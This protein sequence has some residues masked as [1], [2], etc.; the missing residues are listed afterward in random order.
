M[1]ANVQRQL[2]QWELRPDGAPIGGTGSTIVPVR[3]SDGTPAVL[4]LGTASALEHLVLRRWGGRGAARLF[5]ADPRRHAL[6]LERLHRIDLTSRP[7]VEACYVVAGLY[8]H[9]HVPA[10]PQLPTVP[11]LLEQW[12]RDFQALP[13]SAPIPHRLVQ[14]AMALSDGLSALP[15]DSVAHG[16][17]HYGNV[18]AADRAPWLA[19]APHPLNADPAYDLAP[20]L[21]SWWDELADDVRGGVRRRFYA[22]IDAGGFDEDR[23]RAWVLLRVVREATRVLASDPSAVTRYV[24]LAKAVQD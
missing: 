18:L 12:L 21:W 9:L 13:R 6:L 1:G 4:K 2:Q 16:N 3:T 15:A 20:M 8:R 5:R 24:A 17:L 19:I 7:D 11:A 23:A 14:Q 22:L 10:M